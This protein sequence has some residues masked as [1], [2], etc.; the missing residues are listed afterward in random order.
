ML[1]LFISLT[2]FQIL[3]FSHKMLEN[4]L[5][6]MINS[7]LLRKII[8]FRIF[9]CVMIKIARGWS[10]SIIKKNCVTCKK[11][12]DHEIIQY[13]HK[14]GIGPI[15]IM[16]KGSRGFG[17]EC[18]S[19][20][21][22]IEMGDTGI[23]KANNIKYYDKRPATKTSDVSAVTRTN[24][25]HKRKYP[26][27]NAKERSKIIKHNRR[28]GILSG[29]FGIIIGTIIAAF[30]GIWGLWFSV[31]FVVLAFYLALEDPERK[32]RDLIKSGKKI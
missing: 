7:I 13:Q 31:L 29:I 8:V 24:K 9:M 6:T 19:C 14:R 20:H 32:H 11:K 27:L 30:T 25:S 15:P 26:V 21:N 2:S 23:S 18:K 5:N 3:Y 16:G 12:Y 17:Y 4:L 22:I 1:I 10:G 28:E